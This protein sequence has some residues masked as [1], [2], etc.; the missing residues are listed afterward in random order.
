VTNQPLDLTAE[1]LL[2]PPLNSLP[3]T[4]EKDDIMTEYHPCSGKPTKVEHFGDYGRTDKTTKSSP[5]DKEPW[6]PFFHSRQDFM[7]A[8]VV[9]QAG[10]TKNQ[11]ETLMDT[12]HC[13]L[14]G[15]GTFSLQKYD[16]I[17]SAWERASR[18]LTTVSFQLVDAMSA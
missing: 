9:L 5:Y 11:C 8:E 12:F 1:E 17:E 13:C 18:A 14:R 15:E 16:D 2:M 7:F 3:C 6:K 10:L 4:F